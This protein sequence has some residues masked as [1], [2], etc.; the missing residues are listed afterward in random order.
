MTPSPN[1]RVALVDGD[2][3][4]YRCA[5]SCEPSKTREHREER[6]V[7]LGRANDLLN[8]IG[9]RI[10]VDEYRIFLGGTRNFRKELYPDYKANRANIRRPE[11]L[12]AVRDHMVR[13]WGATIVEGYEADDRIAMEAK[14]NFIVVAIDKDLLQIP[15]EHYNPVKDVFQVVD[16][17]AAKIHLYTSM[18][19]GD[20]SDNLRG[21]DGLGPIK[22]ARELSGLTSEEA[23][24]RVNAIYE[25]HGR[26]FLF[27]YRLFRLL[28]S[29]EEYHEVL[30]EISISK[31]EG[32]QVATIS[33]GHVP[34]VFPT[35]DAQ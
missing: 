20:S 35:T 7:A 19:I 23:F 6:F 5:A 21:I 32:T 11:H 29:E 18:L 28:K 31:G 16:D 30:N 17:E 25:E 13:K 27:S 2:F 33:E 9:S 3:I 24:A 12:D 26:D 1:K 15:G 10:E 22:S 4:A 34:E 8:R 14:G